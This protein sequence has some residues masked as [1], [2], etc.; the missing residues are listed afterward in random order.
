M[1]QIAKQLCASAI[2]DTVAAVFATVAAPLLILL[3]S[4]DAEQRHGRSGAANQLAVE[5]AVSPILF[6]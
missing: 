4:L 1:G 5:S 2:G 3:A 6:G